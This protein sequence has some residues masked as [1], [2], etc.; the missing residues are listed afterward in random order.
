[1]N[2]LIVC[3][4]AF[5]LAVS[6]VGCTHIRRGLVARCTTSCQPIPSKGKVLLIRGIV[7]YWPGISDFETCLRERGFDVRQTWGGAY[8]PGVVDEMI[9]EGSHHRPIHIVGYSLGGNSAMMACREF[10]D[11]GV[12]IASL[13]TLDTPYTGEVPTNVSRPHNF[14][15]PRDTDWIPAFRG[16]PMEAESRQTR[17]FNHALK[18][19]VFHFGVCADPKIQEMLANHILQFT[20]VPQTNVQARPESIPMP[21][22]ELLPEAQLRSTGGEQKAKA[23]QQPPPVPSVPST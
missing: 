4:T 21:K 12:R 20:Q 9:A 3:F 17:V 8:I 18:D 11:R 16:V 19:S 5:L 23:D 7:G 15:Q 1:M 10:R 13:T 6:T 14:Y 2:R 22:I